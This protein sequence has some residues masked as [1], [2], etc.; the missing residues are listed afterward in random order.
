MKLQNIFAD[1]PQN[2][3]NEVFDLLIKT[4]SVRIERIVSKGHQSPESGWY[5]QEKN[6]WVLVLK[7]KAILTFEDKQPINL[8]KGDCINIPPHKK[9]KVTWT[10]PDNE[11]IWLAVHY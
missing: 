5:D 1:V 11:T 6:E 8:N 9:H 3:E 10:D 2:L 7:G 4:E